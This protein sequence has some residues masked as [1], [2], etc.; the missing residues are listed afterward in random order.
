MDKLRITVALSALMTVLS[1]PADA[2]QLYRYLNAEGNIVIDYQVPAELIKNGYEVLGKDG[3]VLREVPRQLTQ[4]ELQDLSDEEKRQKTELEEKERIRKWDES[5]LLRYSSVE[6]LDAAR[7]RALRELRIRITIL[8]GN[9]RS[10]KSSV[11]AEQAKAANVERAGGEVDMS[12]LDRI[13]TLQQEIAVI[14]RAI[15]DRQ[16]EIVEVEKSFQK[17]IERF[18]MLT[19]LVKMRRQKSAE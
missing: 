13:D 15:K 10:L 8:R 12:L 16:K 9:A 18:E 4:Q 7:E 14:E 19:D 17:D 2:K 11:E 6:D 3:T 1:L 5:L